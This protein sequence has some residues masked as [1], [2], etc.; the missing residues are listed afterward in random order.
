MDYRHAATSEKE[1]VR[2]GNPSK[3]SKGVALKEKHEGMEHERL[4]FFASG[5]GTRPWYPGGVEASIKLFAPFY[6]V[7]IR[8][9]VN[10]SI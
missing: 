2:E 1:R 5:W 3:D 6:G 9:L 10:G 7:D 8:Y 4:T